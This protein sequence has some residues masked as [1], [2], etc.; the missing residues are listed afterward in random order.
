[1]SHIHKMSNVSNLTSRINLPSD[2]KNKNNKTGTAKFTCYIGLFDINHVENLYHEWLIVFKYF[3]SNNIHMYCSN[4]PIVY[5][6]IYLQNKNDIYYTG[7]V[8]DWM[9]FIV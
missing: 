6:D 7:F 9:R 4:R 8:K 3:L 2:N 5:K 1:M